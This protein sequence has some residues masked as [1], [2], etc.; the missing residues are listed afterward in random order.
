MDRLRTLARSAGRVVGWVSNLHFFATVGASLLVTAIVS[1]VALT[2][3]FVASMPWWATTM[4]VVGL[5]ALALAGTTTGLRWVGSHIDQRRWQ[6]GH[7]APAISERVMV[8]VIPEEL[9]ALFEGRLVVQADKEATSFRGKWLTDSGPLGD[10][11]SFLDLLGAFSVHF[12]AARIWDRWAFPFMRFKDVD[13]LAVLPKGHPITVLGQIADVS[14]TTVDLT[15]CELVADGSDERLTALHRK[16]QRLL[17]LAQQE[18][19]DDIRIVHAKVIQWE[20]EVAAALE[21]A[22]GGPGEWAERIPDT[23]WADIDPSAPQT[24]MDA[25]FL[26]IKLSHLR[27]RIGQSSSDAISSQDQT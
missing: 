6:A 12:D 19:G 10:V 15:H 17:D 5:F 24:A 22:P 11:S 7:T 26:E 3:E 16:G 4:L 21:N 27:R 20:W 2:S 23:A 1:T 13:R 25:R 14:P 9:V 8:D 18:N